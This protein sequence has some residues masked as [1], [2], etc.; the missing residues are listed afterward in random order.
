MVGGRNYAES[1]LNRATDD[2]RQPGSTFKK[3]VYAAALE[4][5]M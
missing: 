3:I 5:G 2:L 1:Q 4:D